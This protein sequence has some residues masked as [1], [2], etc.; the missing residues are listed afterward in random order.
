M[1]WAMPYA[2]FELTASGLK[3]LSC[4]IRRVKNSMGRSLSAAACDRVRQ[5]SVARGGFASL[6]DPALSGSVLV[7]AHAGSSWNAESTSSA[8]AKLSRKL[9]GQLIPL[10]IALH[11]VEAPLDCK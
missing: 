5:T 2:P 8:P 6:F 4:Q 10:D 7:S 11:L 3:R 9:G 1:N